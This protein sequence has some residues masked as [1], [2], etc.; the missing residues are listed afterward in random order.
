MTATRQNLCCRY[1]SMPTRRC[2]SL[3][4]NPCIGGYCCLLIL[5]AD[6]NY[7]GSWDIFESQNIE[8]TRSFTRDFFWHSCGTFHLKQYLVK[9]GL[10]GY[11]VQIIFYLVQPLWYCGT[12]YLSPSSPLAAKEIIP[13]CLVSIVPC[14]KRWIEI[15]GIQDGRIS[16][17]PFMI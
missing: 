14:Q 11:W 12:V 16:S 7:G 5:G 1:L 8:I 6:Q 9:P 3:G 2:M 10:S 17:F 15:D 4:T 13:F